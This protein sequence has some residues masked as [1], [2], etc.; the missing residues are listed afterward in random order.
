M[1]VKT[2]TGDELVMHYQIE[3]G[4]AGCDDPEGYIAKLFDI[5]VDDTGCVHE[6]LR[7]FPPMWPL[8]C[9]LVWWARIRDGLLE[10]FCAADEWHSARSELLLPAMQALYEAGERDFLGTKFENPLLA[11]AP[12]ALSRVALALTEELLKDEK[13]TCRVGESIARLLA[14]IPSTG[15]RD[16]LL[17]VALHDPDVAIAAAAAV[18]LGDVSARCKCHNPITLWIIGLDTKSASTV[19]RILRTLRTVEQTT[20]CRVSGDLAYPTSP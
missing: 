19:S 20:Y 13:R 15:S 5:I 6:K 17:Q 4:A 14:V 3:L 2:V 9:E 16:A 7:L 8:P 10:R 18:A 11:E 1:G 12:E